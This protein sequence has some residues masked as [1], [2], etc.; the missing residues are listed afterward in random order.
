MFLEDSQK[1]F[2]HNKGK[3]ANF[4]KKERTPVCLF[5]E[6][7]ACFIR[8]GENAFFMS[9]KNTFHKSLW[10]RSAIDDN[11]IFI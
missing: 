10:K 2:L 3:L 1:I 7:F 6:P 9:E 4:I 8:A 5:D 11:E